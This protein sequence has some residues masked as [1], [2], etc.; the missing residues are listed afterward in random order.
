MGCGLSSKGQHLGPEVTELRLLRLGAVRSATALTALR[1]LHPLAGE[2][3]D[4]VGCL[5]YLTEQF[6]LVQWQVRHPVCFVNA[7]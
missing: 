1:R 5:P 2:A 6:A 3:A 7:P 4:V